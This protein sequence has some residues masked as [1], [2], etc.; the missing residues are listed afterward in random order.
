VALPF[1]TTVKR[2]LYHSGGLDD[3]DF[4]TYF[5][6]SS[7]EDFH[8]LV[9]ALQNVKEFSYTRQFGNPLLLGTVQSL[10]QVIEVLAQ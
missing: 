1:L 4:I 5:E 7:L 6:T 2:K 8:G 3:V 9:L 10:D